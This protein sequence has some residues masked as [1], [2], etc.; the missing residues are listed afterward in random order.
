MCGH[1]TIEMLLRVR[2]I[3][4]LLYTLGRL[5]TMESNTCGLSFISTFSSLLR[6]LQTSVHW[7]IHVSVWEGLNPYRRSSALHSS[8]RR[9]RHIASTS[10]LLTS[11]SATNLLCVTR[12]RATYMLW[13]A[14]SPIT[15]SWTRTSECGGLW[16]ANT[17][18]D[19]TAWLLLAVSF[20]VP[21]HP[22]D[23]GPAVP[24]S[25][26]ECLLGVQTLPVHCI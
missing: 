9:R 19:H 16:S 15:V 12:S 1:I 6:T 17:Q 18:P 20:L 21:R 4:I 24:V 8:L 22:D 25:I 11:A 7:P 5:A 2:S 14:V 13:Q 26:L 3:P 23:L 10:C